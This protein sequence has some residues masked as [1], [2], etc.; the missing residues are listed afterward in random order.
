MITTHPSYSDLKSTKVSNLGKKETL[1]EMLFESYMQPIYIAQCL[2][3][4]FPKLDPEM[5]NKVKV[6]LRT[7]LR[8]NQ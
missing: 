2:R 5:R 4:R 1:I 6:K 8:K 7:V 3:L